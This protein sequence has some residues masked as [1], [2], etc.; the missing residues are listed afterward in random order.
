MGEP[1]FPGDALDAA[2]KISDIVKATT[3]SDAFQKQT[4]GT[5]G[6][7]AAVDRAI[8]A[9]KKSMVEQVA[10]DARLAN[11]RSMAYLTA[12]Q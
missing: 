3:S 4:G 7:R 10:D 2:S 9:A 6:Q 11:M 5:A 1:A 8:A 12:K